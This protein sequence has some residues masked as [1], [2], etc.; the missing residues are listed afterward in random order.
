MSG[1]RPGPRQLTLTCVSPP[2]QTR[3]A[4]RA[5]LLG[6][7]PRPC[8]QQ[9]RPRTVHRHGRKPLDYSHH[10]PAGP[11]STQSQGRPQGAAG[12]LQDQ[13]KP[14]T[15]CSGLTHSPPGTRPRRAGLRHSWRSQPCTPAPRSSTKLEK[16]FPPTTAMGSRSRG[17]GSLSL[18]S[19]HSAPS[20][21]PNSPSAGSPFPEPPKSWRCRWDTAVPQQALAPGAPARTCRRLRAQKVPASIGAGHACPRGPA[22]TRGRYNGVR[23]ASAVGCGGGAPSLTCGSIREMGWRGS[24]AGAPNPAKDG[25]GRRKRSPHV[26]SPQKGDWKHVP[27]QYDR[28]CG[29]PGRAGSNWSSTSLSPS[30]T[31][32]F[33]PVTGE[34]GSVW[35]MVFRRTRSLSCT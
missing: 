22:G 30:C 35:R 9:R 13:D 29:V 3:T 10:A 12:R 19:S 23:C 26:S 34:G 31:S 11:V 28:V 21:P 2:Q 7:R 25:W 4:G 24:Q 14:H 15:T 32:P 16:A 6:S 20:Q 17:Q 27:M 33:S 5:E 1:S 18:P 8:G